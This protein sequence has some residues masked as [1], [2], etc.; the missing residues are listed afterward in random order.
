MRKDGRGHGDHDDDP[1]PT[2]LGTAGLGAFFLLV[3]W[4]LA[5]APSFGLW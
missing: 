4:A 5:G 3:G 2:W 1:G